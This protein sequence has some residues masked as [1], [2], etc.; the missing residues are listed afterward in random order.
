MDR[1]V[2][3]PHFTCSGYEDCHL[4]V[5]FNYQVALILDLKCF[6]FLIFIKLYPQEILSIVSSLELPKSFSPTDMHLPKTVSK[7]LD[8]KSVGARAKSMGQRM[9]CSLKKGLEYHQAAAG[10]GMLPELWNICVKNLKTH[11]QPQPN[12]GSTVCSEP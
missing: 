1:R 11:P 2:Q 7:C 6:P 12:V 4:L 10:C 9:N 5:P 3:L 8:W